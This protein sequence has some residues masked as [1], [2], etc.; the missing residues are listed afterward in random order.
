MTCGG[1]C[2][3]GARVGIIGS[4]S[5][6]PGGDPDE[7]VG[8]PTRGGTVRE[9]ALYEHHSISGQGSAAEWERRRVRRID[10]S[11]RLNYRRG[12]YDSLSPS[13]LFSHFFR[14]FPSPFH[15]CSLDHYPSHT[16]TS[17]VL[18]VYGRIFRDNDCRTILWSTPW[19]STR[20]I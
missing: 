13:C 9:A 3:G 4:H 17:S 10:A 14:P 12:S 5:A 8:T 1:W 7:F 18:S 20:T 16:T 2:S 19:E 15:A 11:F 6:F